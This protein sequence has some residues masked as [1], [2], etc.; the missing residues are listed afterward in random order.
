MTLVKLTRSPTINLTSF[1]FD[2][3]EVSCDSK[4]IFIIFSRIF[5]MF[6]SEK[7]FYKV[8]EFLNKE[9]SIEAINEYLAFFLFVLRKDPQTLP[10]E[11]LFFSLLANRAIHYSN[12]KYMYCIVNIWK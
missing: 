2:I 4:L 12:E 10:N 8:V 9:F 5:M 7:M 11:K 6:R 1:S 3:E